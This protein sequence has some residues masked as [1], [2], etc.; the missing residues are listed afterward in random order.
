[1]PP[2]R[3][4]VQ[5]RGGTTRNKGGA[6]S[7]RLREERRQVDLPFAVRRPQ[8]GTHEICEAAIRKDPLAIE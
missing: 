8:Y 6:H 2:P 4:K 3:E 5:V 1:M 7:H